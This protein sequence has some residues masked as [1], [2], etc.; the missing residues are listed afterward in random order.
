MPPS[1]SATSTPI[2]SPS[3]FLSFFDSPFMVPSLG[4][5]TSSGSSSSSAPSH[6]AHPV[7]S[8]SLFDLSCLQPDPTSPP[9]VTSPT[10]AAAPHSHF[11][12]PGSAAASSSLPTSTSSPSLRQPSRPSTPP[13][14]AAAAPASVPFFEFTQLTSW[15]DSLFREADGEAA[16][17]ESKEEENGP[18]QGRGRGDGAADDRQRKERKA[19]S[20]LPRVSRARA[21]VHTAG[22]A[23]SM[24]AL[25]SHAR[26]K[27]QVKEQTNDEDATPST[28]SPSTSPSSPSALPPAVHPAS[29]PMSIAR[30]SPRS[31]KHK[32]TTLTRAGS[33]P[34]RTWPNATPTKDVDDSIVRLLNGDVSAPPSRAAGALS[35]LPEV[36][37]VETLTPDSPSHP[38]RVVH[39]TKPGGGDGGR[40]EPQ[41]PGAL[42]PSV[43]SAPQSSSSSPSSAAASDAEALPVSTAA[44][45]VPADAACVMSSALSDADL[46]YFALENDLVVSVDAV[47]DALTVSAEWI[48]R[49]RDA[50]EHDDD[51]EEDGEDER[52]GLAWEEDG[53]VVDVVELHVRRAATAAKP[54]KDDE[55]DWEVCK[56][57]EAQEDDYELV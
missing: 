54:R 35:P 30:T 12:P 57:Q 36:Q 2:F 33:Q 7:I 10:P 20:A 18:A 41:R 56:V 29:S 5:P 6:A 50:F 37:L 8:P 44:S 43:P 32:P 17:A 21:V 15:L 53:Q 23:Q 1:S 46:D 16:H 4:S 42:S 11:F 39:V 47:A 26:R 49:A 22:A 48:N 31:L 25:T 51:N 3:S 9:V 28:S 45:A 24:R 14:A 40:G 34:Q 38:I 13:T 55:D 19:I 52:E 27:S